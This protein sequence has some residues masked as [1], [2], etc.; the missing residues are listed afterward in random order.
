MPKRI[1]RKR[2]KGWRM[3][4]GAVYVGRGSKFG[5]PFAY[6]TDHALA[7]EPAVDEPT[8]SWEYEGRISADGIRHDYHHPD[9]R[10]IVCH[11]RYMTREEVVETY[12][13]ALLGDDT[14][15][16]RGALPGPRGR[17]FGRWV[18]KHPNQHREYTTV[19]DVRRELAGKDLACWCPLYVPCHA[20]VLLEVANA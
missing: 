14:P 10:I 3:P 13:R 15:S 2:I 11:I 6:R 20:D 12:R 16:M 4:E 1:Q 5:N 8:A 17:W 19:D 9:G 18:G 7:R